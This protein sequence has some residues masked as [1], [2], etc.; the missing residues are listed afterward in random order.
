MAGQDTRF[1]GEGG[2]ADYSREK[3]RVWIQKAA[4][5]GDESA[6]AHLKKLNDEDEAEVVRKEAEDELKNPA[7]EYCQKHGPCCST[8][9]CKNYCKDECYYC[10]ADKIVAAR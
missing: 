6:I 2:L 5:G 9:T 10:W 8:P 7:C 4:E 3:A 1:I